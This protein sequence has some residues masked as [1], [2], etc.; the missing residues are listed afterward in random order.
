MIDLKKIGVH[1]SIDIWDKEVFEE[2]MMEGFE[3]CQTSHPSIRASRWRSWHK[4]M[5]YLFCD[6]SN[7]IE[8]LEAEIKELKSKGTE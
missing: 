3:G 5:R 4:G 8:Q 2:L 7:R 1:E 6:L